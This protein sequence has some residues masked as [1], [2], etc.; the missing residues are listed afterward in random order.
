MKNSTSIPSTIVRRANRF[1]LVSAAVLC[2]SIASALAGSNED[3]PEPAGDPYSNMPTIA[4]LGVR[5]GR[6]LGIPE[7]AKGPAI[8][9][10]KGCRL[11]DLGQG[12]YMITDNGYQSMFMVYDKGVVGVD[13]PTSYAQYSLKGIA[14]VTDNP[15][16]HVI[17]SH[18]H[19]DHIGG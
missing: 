17:Y 10:A 19:N 1:A 11:Q 3:A 2:M 6:H 16:T 9:P 18:S 14:E 5:I 15:I 7:S 12:L 13:A 8:D 4:P